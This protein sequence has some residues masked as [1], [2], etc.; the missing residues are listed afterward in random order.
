MAAADAEQQ[1]TAE[2]IVRAKSPPQ[3][4]ATLDHADAS[5]NIGEKATFTIKV[6]KKDGAPVQEKMLVQVILTQDGIKELVPE[7]KIEVGAEP[8]MIEHS[9]AEPGF[10]RLTAIGRSWQGGRCYV[11]SIVV[12]ACEPERITPVVT[13]PDDFDDFWEKGRKRLAAIP[14]DLKQEK[15]EAL[16]DG[17]QDTYKIS[18]ANIDDTRIRGY[19]LIPKTGKAKYPAHIAVAPAGMG[20]PKDN[21]VGYLNVQARNICLYM[22][23]YDHELGLPKDY[24]KTFVSKDGDVRGATGEAEKYFFYRAILGID[25]AISWLASRKDVDTKRIVYSGSSQGGGMGLVLTGLNKSITAAA[26]SI[27]A[28]CDHLAFRAGRQPGWPGVLARRYTGRMTP[29]KIEAIAGM[30]PYFDAVNFAKKITVPVFL[31]MGYQDVT[32]PP[33]GIY[34]AYNSI[35]SPKQIVYDPDAAHKVSPKMAAV[36]YPWIREKLGLPAAAGVS[37]KK[38]TE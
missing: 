15:V 18:F 38:D 34:S 16:C 37:E 2:K 36:L 31:C 19:L 30:M 25:R 35:S 9:I 1:K 3:V 27:P 22:G 28:L 29:E 20:K 12:A 4:I 33:S 6:V 23:V 13:M 8:L 21:F 11:K 7:E 10:Y 26:V 32:C 24:Y 17:T 14:L 5:Y